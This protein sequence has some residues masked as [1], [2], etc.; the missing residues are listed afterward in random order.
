M[1]NPEQAMR[2][3]GTVE[4]VFSYGKCGF[5]CTPL[6]EHFY[7]SPKSF[8]SEAKRLKPGMMVTFLASTQNG[9]PMAMEIDAETPEF[10][11]SAMQAYYKGKRN[12]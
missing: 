11:R 5:I 4:K 12:N 7:F 9:K 2:K 10:I 1:A 8:P 6:D 3:M